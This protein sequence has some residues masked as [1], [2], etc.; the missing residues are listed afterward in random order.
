MPRIKTAAVNTFWRRR[1]PM[2][3]KVLSRKRK[4]RIK[5]KKPFYKKK[6][7]WVF[8]LCFSVF[9]ALF[10]FLLFAQTFQI[11]ELQLSGNKKVSGEE[12]REIVETEIETKV[13]FST[14]TI[15]L[16][17]PSK[18]QKSVL[19]KFPQIAEAKTRRKLPNILILEI[20]E[21]IPFANVC[22]VLPNFASETLGGQDAEQC[23]KVDKNGIV[24]EEG[25]E[26]NALTVYF[27]EGGIVL[28][29][30]LVREKYLQSMMEIRK[31]LKENLEIEIEKFTL[32][33]ERLDAKTAQGFEIYFDLEGD[34]PDQLVNLELTLQEKISPEE[35]GNLQYIDLRFGNRVYFK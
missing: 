4:F 3:K 18:I 23:F 34:V 25:K 6:G 2:R 12:L 15:F 13:I 20:Q 1:I 5:K 29:K 19:E 30:S 17:N 32:S 8:V 10:Y 7:F 24:F 31:R 28:G 27:P 14:K 33:G 35:R 22:Q 9:A 11:K 16:V 26:E 21:R